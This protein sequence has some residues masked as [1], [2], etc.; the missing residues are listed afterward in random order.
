MIVLALILLEVFYLASVLAG[1]S[2]NL[3]VTC[4]A[5]H[6]GLCPYVHLSLISVVRVI[7]FCTILTLILY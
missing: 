7:P 3:A 2:A 5:N 6:S 4:V 1:L